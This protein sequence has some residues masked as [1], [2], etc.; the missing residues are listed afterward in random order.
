MT[1]DNLQQ[2]NTILQRINELASISES[3]GVITRTFGTEAFIKGRTL[4]AH[5]M[6]EAGLQTHI[7]NIGNVRGRLL[8]QSPDA[9]TLVI[10]S[11]IDTVINAGKFDGPLGVLLGISLLEQLIQQRTNLPFH[12][13]LIAFCDEEGCRFHTTY[14]GSKVVAGHFDKDLFSQRDATGFTLQEV[15]QHM[16]GDPAVLAQDA[17]PAKNWLGYFEVHIE[18]GPVLFEKDI[19]V[20]IVTAIAGQKRIAITFHGEAGHAGTVPMDMRHDALCA[21]AEFILEAERFAASHL[22]QVV[23]TVGTLQITH[24]ASNVIPGEVQITLDLRSANQQVLNSCHSHLERLAFAICQQRRVNMQWQPVQESNPVTCNAQL[25]YLLAQAVQQSGYEV[26]KLVSGA[27]HD[28]VAISPVAP[29]AMLFVRC[30][31]GISHNPLENVELK[32]LAAAVK[33]SA[34]F[35]HSLIQ[36]HNRG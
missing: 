18:Q 34:A 10:A 25:N 36:K 27:G 15:I 17:I 13:E 9:K 20:G 29:V 16:G 33:V 14:L 3:P 24:A 4:V 26:I 35:I 1:P 31:E 19:P 32:D 28:G 12:I 6:Q 8:S 2:A 11:H 21:A 5:W 30:F 22:Q 7:D 23:A